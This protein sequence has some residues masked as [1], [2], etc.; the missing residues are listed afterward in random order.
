MSTLAPVHSVVHGTRVAIHVEGE[1]DVFGAGALRQTILDLIEAGWTDLVVD[2]HRVS[3][4]DSTGLGVLVGALKR[5]R[6]HGGRLQ[7]VTDQER[8]VKVLRMT[9]LSQVFTVHGT[10]DD[11]LAEGTV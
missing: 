11:A 5:T 10:L 7:L 2:L 1:V 4:M 8:M 9:A 6:A 3:F